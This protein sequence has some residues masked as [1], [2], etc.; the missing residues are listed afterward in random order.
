MKDEIVSHQMFVI[1]MYF[2]I[3]MHLPLQWKYSLLLDSLRYE[4][5]EICADCVGL[6]NVELPPFTSIS[7]LSPLS[8]APAIVEGLH[9]SS[10]RFD[11]VAAFSAPAAAAIA[12]SSANVGCVLL[13]FFLAGR[14]IVVAGE[15]K[16]YR[17]N[18]NNCHS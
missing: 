10:L 18:V 2:V 5:K 11:F 12:C 8:P 17:S 3:E 16:A 14:C 4:E 1:A 15:V 9:W 6:R 13:R 7:T